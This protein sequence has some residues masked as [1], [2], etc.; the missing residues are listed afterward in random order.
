MSIF[1]CGFWGLDYCKH[2]SQG[3]P[4]SVSILQ[5]PAAYVPLDPDAPALLSAR[6]MKRCGLRYC[7]LQSDLL[8]QFQMAFSNLMSIEVC[9]VWSAHNLTLVLVQHRTTAAPK[10]EPNAD[11]FTPAAVPESASQGALAYILHTSGTTG[12]PKTVRV[13]HKCIVPNI[14]HLRSLF[15]MTPDDVVFLASP[16][17]FDPSVVEIFLALSSGARL[18]I[19]PTVIKRMP[20]RLAHVLFK[21]HKTTVLQVTPTLLGRF[22]R[23]VLQEEVLSACSSLRVLALGGEACPSLAL[24]RSWRQQGNCT[25]IYNIYGITEVSCWA[26][27]YHLPESLLQ[28][29]DVTESSLPLGPP[30][31]ETTVELRDEDGCVITQGEGQVFIGGMDRVCL[32]DDEVT[33]A[34]GTMRS[35]GD[36][37][38]IRDTHLYYLGRRDRLVKRH[39]QRLHLDTLQQVVM[40]LPQVEACAVGLYEGS[41]LVAFVVVCSTSGEQNAT[42]T[43]SP[44]EHQVEHREETAPS[45]RSLQ[46]AILHRLSQLLPSHSVPDTLVLV[47]ALPLSSHGKVSMGEL[48]KI[49]QRQRAG[50]ESHSALG[51]METL[52]ETLQSL[53][54]ETLGLTEDEAIQEDS[55][56][57]FSGGDSLQA[58][59][60]CDDITTA[61][62]V[63]S[64]GLLEVILD[65]SFS[66]VLCHVA[67][68]TLTLPSEHSWTS[69][70]VAMKRPADPLSSAQ[71]KRQHTDPYSTTTA[72]WPLGVVVSSMRKA[73]RCTVL[74]RAGEVVEM[75]QPDSLRTNENSHSDS[76]GPIKR[77]RNTQEKGANESTESNHSQTFGSNKRTEHNHSKAVETNEPSASSVTPP[78]GLGLR[79]S[80]ES[81]TG[82][83][84]DASPVLLVQ[85]GADRAS[86]G[87]RAT[88]FIGSHSHRM[89]ALDLTTG[90]L[91][92]ER[93]LGDRIESSSA[94]SRC[95]RL[96]VVGCYD[97]GVYFLCV[98]SGETQWVFETGDTVKS[99][100]TVD[101]LTGLVMVGSHDGHI[102]ALDPQVQQCVWKHHCGCGAVFSSP[103]LHPSLRQLYVATLGGHLLCLNPDTGTV[104]WTY[105]RKT[106]FFSSP[107]CSSGHIII[108]SVDGNI[109]CFSH[110]GEMLW[111]YVTDGPVFSSPCITPDKQRV[112][113]GSHDGCVYCL[114]CTDGSLVWR[115]QTP[116]RVYSSPCVF[117]VS[118]WGM[119]GTLVVLASTDGTLCVLDGEDGTLKASLS[120]L[121]ELFSSPVVWERSVVV[122]CRNDFVYCVALTGE[123]K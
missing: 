52:R 105:S 16:L 108:G 48:M 96:V 65:G 73:V 94:V 11:I 68:A 119:E 93:V 10:E 111:Q 29:T 14:L 78:P 45:T 99:C 91:L 21:K 38:Q 31:M 87:P 101:P 15:Q 23:R 77:P 5:L 69:H 92:W 63:T 17:T 47:P 90:G 60:L 42:H 59:R 95:G 19:V 72:E 34:P 43:P 51:D 84:V 117:E 100:P 25:H 30:L 53:W 118:A 81:D 106:P 49:Y 44:V 32:L 61:V 102:Y 114:N 55:N 98:E 27:C 62:E 18:L 39:G 88:V 121:G 97:G 120:L 115:Y 122:G 66:Q 103:C 36:W 89:Q 70:P 40:S 46:K 50:S 109:C 37:V 104:L 33:V 12:L 4:L 8:Q 112:V 107:N 86:G 13:P 6:V 9:A 2:S 20:N 7:V 79:V 71:P 82:R 58:L 24:L 35:T 28:S 1:Q 57:L 26:C 75:G 67:T 64:S 3:D 54:R 56:F 76:E 113:C 80:W 74:R 123:L 83:C 22:G 41:R 116:S 85:R 110:T